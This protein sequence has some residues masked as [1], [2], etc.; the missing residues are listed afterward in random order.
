LLI[1]QRWTPTKLRSAWRPNVSTL[2]GSRSAGPAFPR[3]PW[4]TPTAGFR[5]QLHELFTAE[6]TI[7]V[8]IEL[9]EQLIRIGRSGTLTIRSSTSFTAASLPTTTLS[10]PPWAIAPALAHC[11][12]RCLSFFVVEFP[13][14]VGIELFNHPRP[15]LAIT[16]RTLIVRLLC[17]R[18]PQGKKR[19]RQHQCP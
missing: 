15:H 3:A 18:L 10:P 16:A 8:L 2:L 19:Q 1:R 12:T 17:R 11:L 9:I 14:A 7:F 13:I 5:R 6:L 4:S